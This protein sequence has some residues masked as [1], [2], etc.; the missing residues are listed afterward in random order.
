MDSS[1]APHIL[2]NT[3][4]CSLK[5]GKIRVWGGLNEYF[6]AKH[7]FFV[8]MVVPYERT[9]PPYHHDLLLSIRKNDDDRGFR[10]VVPHTTNNCSSSKL[11]FRRKVQHE[12]ST[13]WFLLTRETVASHHHLRC[14]TKCSPKLAFISTKNF[15][16]VVQCKACRKN[17]ANGDDVMIQPRKFN[18]SFLIVFPSSA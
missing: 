1:A 12:N 15:I 5:V 18:I 10:F 4:T 3:T 17:G 9:V 7:L 8:Q 2:F 14:S 13:N 16:S 11:N 6:L